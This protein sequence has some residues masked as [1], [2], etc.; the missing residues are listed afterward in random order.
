MSFHLFQVKTVQLVKFIEFKRERK[1]Q[2]FA[3]QA[4]K[5]EPRNH[6]TT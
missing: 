3:L 2:N 4:M 6:L 1:E 5:G